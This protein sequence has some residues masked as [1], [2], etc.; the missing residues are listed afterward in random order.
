MKVIFLDIDGVLVCY[1][2]VDKTATRPK[3]KTDPDNNRHLPHVP[4]MNNL[5]RILK[6]TGAKMVLSST[7]RH[8]E[9][10]DNTN[11]H[12]IKY[13]LSEPCIDETPSLD[14]RMDNGLWKNAQRGDEIIKWMEGK[15]IESFV[16]LDDDSDMSDVKDRLVKCSMD[17]GLTEELAD[18]AIEILN[19][20]TNKEE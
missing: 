10:L 6:E 4:A 3:L 1:D 9:G 8:L 2:S 12:F 14:Q 5:N 20:T 7:W 19:K 13:G 18:R 16:I 11:A 17:H 15:D